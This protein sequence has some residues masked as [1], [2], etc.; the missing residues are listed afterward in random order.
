[1]VTSPS[2]RGKG[3]GKN[4]MKKSIQACFETYGDTPIKIS[5]QYHLQKFYK[6]FGFKSIG[7]QYLE[8]NIPHIAMVKCNYQ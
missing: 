1:V 6:E 7:D 4:L 3:F 8:D 5:A 2:V